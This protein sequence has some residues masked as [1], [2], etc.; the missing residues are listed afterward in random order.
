LAFFL[1][2]TAEKRGRETAFLKG[3]CKYFQKI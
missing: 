1:I 2:E 3:T